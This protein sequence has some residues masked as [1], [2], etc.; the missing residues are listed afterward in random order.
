MDG[1]W[2]SCGKRSRERPRK[3]RRFSLAGDTEAARFCPPA[4]LIFGFGD[5]GTGGLWALEGVGGG[6]GA[7]EGCRSGVG[8][9]VGA[10]DEGSSGVWEP[11]DDMTV[12]WR[13]REAVLLPL[14]KAG[15]IPT[16]II[17][18]PPFPS[19]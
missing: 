14:V 9:G 13:G 8:G 12:A 5:S 4:P 7:V 6:V 2:G 1:R 10:A 15:R 17:P 16:R 11:L 19:T 18:P 3:E